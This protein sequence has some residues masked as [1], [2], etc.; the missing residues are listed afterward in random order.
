MN[1]D[2]TIGYTGLD[3]SNLFICV[4]KLNWIQCT[5]TYLYAI[6]I[7]LYKYNFFLLLTFFFFL[8]TTENWKKNTVFILT[9]TYTYNFS[10]FAICWKIETL[11]NYSAM[12]LNIC[13]LLISPQQF[14]FFSIPWKCKFCVVSANDCEL[15]ALFFFFFF[16]GSLSVSVC[17]RWK[18]TGYSHN[19]SVCM[20][21]T[22]IT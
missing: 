6:G 10:S 11:L 16:L 13:F 9:R 18:R 5:Y 7:N 12:R 21:G 1:F 2:Y 15:S 19:V 3:A 14:A 20:Y 4:F 8:P 22:G 17:C